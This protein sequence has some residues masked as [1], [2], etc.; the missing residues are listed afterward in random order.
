MGKK[1]EDMTDEDLDA[2]SPEDMLALQTG[3]STGEDEGDD[4]GDGDEGGEGGDQGGDEGEGDEGGEGDGDDE[5]AEAER[6]RLER[7]A[8][9]GGDG[10]GDEGGEGEEGQRGS[11]T[12]P[13]ARFNEKVQEA[14]H[15]RE[16]ALALIEAGKAGQ[17]P[18]QTP[19]S[20]QEEAP[21]RPEYDFKAAMREYHKLVLEGEDEKAASKLD[22]IEDKREA[23]RVFD[24]QQVQAQAETS[25]VQRI[26]ARQEAANKAVVIDTLY[27]TYP[28]LNNEHKDADEA[29]ILAVNAKAKALVAEGVSPSEALR[30]AGEAIGERFAKVLGV[31]KP[32][33]GQDGQG[34]KPGETKPGKDTRTPAA[35]RRGLEVRQPATQKS[36]VGNREGAS[37]LSIADLTDEQ[38]ERLEKTDP[39]ALAELRGDNR[40]PG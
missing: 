38:L 2:L 28:F 39:A 15:W 26:T 34:K 29:A 17:A 23:I 13:H 40:I 8:N 19:A 25:A 37:K 12:V 24:L 4:E 32:A 9:E 30:R 31:S 16:T 7:L 35:V 14:K 18:A 6:L 27:K 5:S 21:Q 33:T 20:K 10:D 1:I 11:A 22:E 36:G 3:G